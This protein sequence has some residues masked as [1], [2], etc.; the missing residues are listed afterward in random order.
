MIQ[1]IVIQ[2]QFDLFYFF[3]LKIRKLY[4]SQHQI[5]AVDQFLIHVLHRTGF[6]DLY[7]LTELML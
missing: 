5:G 2:K 6:Y 3:G 4:R 1:I 7:V